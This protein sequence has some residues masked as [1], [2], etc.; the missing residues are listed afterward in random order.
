[1]LSSKLQQ[2]GQKRSNKNKEPQT[3][4]GSAV[5]DVARP[6]DEVIGLT[7]KLGGEKD[8]MVLGKEEQQADLKPER[9][10]PLQRHLDS[11]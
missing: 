3:D 9:Y 8:Q 11:L 10:V 2:Q 4:L 7:S 6:Q 1:M 5:Q